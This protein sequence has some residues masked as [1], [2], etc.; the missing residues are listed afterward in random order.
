MKALVYTAVNHVEILERPKPV[1]GQDEVLVRIAL[2]G[3]CGSDLHGFL[4]HHAKR[5]PGLILG[6]ETVG[7]VEQG[8]GHLVGQRVVVN[9]L[10]T[11][12]NC[13]NCQGGR[14]NA[15]LTWRLLGFDQTQG[16]FAE[17]VALPIKNVVPIPDH[18]PFT[19]AVLVEPLANAIHLLSMVPR[20]AGFGAT[21]VILGGGTLG[22]LIAIVANARG[23]NVVAVSEPNP[24]RAD[25]L[26]ELGFTKIISPLSTDLRQEVL[27]LTDGEGVAFAVDAVGIENTRKSAVEILRKGGT[28]LLLGLD[29]GS[30]TLDF[31]DIVRRE[32]RLQGSF[33]FTSNDFM[34]ALRFIALG[35][36]EIGNFM[37][38]L[39]MSDGQLGFDRLAKDP[40]NRLKIA[41]SVS[42]E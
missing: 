12:G 15:C 23:F 24:M 3:I 9:P 28:S 5:Q 17:Y 11:C 36:V 35:G 2:T 16:A 26:K 13:R 14:E 1:I 40:G 39:P 8:P 29:H 4:G 19:Q 30:T 34:D 42:A 25:A 6:H 32:I 38:I 33:A 27:K 22:T 31:Q 10:L 18:V 41:L 37:D 20:S 21:G 7:V